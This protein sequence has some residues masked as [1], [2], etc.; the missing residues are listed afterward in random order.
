MEAFNASGRELLELLSGPNGNIVLSP[1]AIGSAMSMALAGA[2]N[3]TGQEMARVLKHSLNQEQIDAANGQVLATLASY[4]RSAVPRTCP[5]GMQLMDARCQTDPDRN[6]VCPFSLH[7][8]GDRCVGGATMPPSASLLAANALMLL[9]SPPRLHGLCRCSQGQI[10]GRSV[11]ER[12][13]RRR[14]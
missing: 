12:E 3:D 13:P 11:P 7:R 10:C 9:N 2:R 5:A 1:Y 14:E 6:G 8:E 4:D